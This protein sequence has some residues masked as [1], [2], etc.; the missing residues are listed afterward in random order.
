VP[1]IIARRLNFEGWPPPGDLG[2][3]SYNRFSQIQR[4][5][6]RI[7]GLPDG[8][9]IIKGTDDVDKAADAVREVC[10]ALG[11]MNG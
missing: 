6:P 11:R 9:A 1:L 10:G 3:I 5:R 8:R 4:R 7:H 2:G